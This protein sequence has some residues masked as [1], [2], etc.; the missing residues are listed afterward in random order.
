MA[1]LVHMCPSQKNPS[2]LQDPE[3]PIVVVANKSDLPVDQNLPHESLEATAIF[4]WENGY[5]QCSAKDRININ[6]IFKELL[7][8]AKSRFDVSVRRNNR[9]PSVTQGFPY[10]AVTRHLPALAMMHHKITR[11]EEYGLKRRQSLPAAP[12]M[13]KLK[14]VEEEDEVFVENNVKKN[15]VKSSNGTPKQRRSSLAHLRR[16]SCKIS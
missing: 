7:N 14:N 13:T 6:K 12:P 1:R 2:N 4:D 5:V 9:R 16:D 10:E 8:Q 15:E 3:C 11:T